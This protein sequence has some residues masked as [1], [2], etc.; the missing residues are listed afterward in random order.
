MDVVVGV[1]V[2]GGGGVSSEMGSVTDGGE[3]KHQGPVSRPASV[4]NKEESNNN[5]RK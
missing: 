2:T 4:R 1:M 3:H 5:G